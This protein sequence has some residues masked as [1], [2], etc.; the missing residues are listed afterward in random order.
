VTAGR[1]HQRL[2]YRFAIRGA[3]FTID[4]AVVTA[5]SGVTT[6]VISPFVTTLVIAAQNR[7][8]SSLTEIGVA[9]YVAGPAIGVLV[10]LGV[11]VACYRWLAASPG[12]LATELSVADARTGDEPTARQAV[13]RGLLLFGP[14]LVSLNLPGGLLPALTFTDPDWTYFAIAGAP[15]LLLLWYPLLG[16][17]VLVRPSGRGLHDRLTGTVVTWADEGEA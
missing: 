16:Y 15:L 5:V 3:A 12:Q 17:S 6:R 8:G 14:V 1:R 2:L 10:A 7:E 11:V 13:A 9:V 4:L